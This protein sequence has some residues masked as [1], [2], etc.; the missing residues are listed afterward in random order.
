MVDATLI[1]VRDMLSNDDD[2][3]LPHRVVFVLHYILIKAN[4]LK[5]WDAKLE[6]LLNGSQLPKG[7]VFFCIEFQG[8]VT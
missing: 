1:H 8:I 6:G 7:G 3:Y 4:Q 2:Y 5:D